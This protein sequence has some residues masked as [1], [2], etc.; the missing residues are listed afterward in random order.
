VRL[1]TIT[2]KHKRRFLSHE[3]TIFALQLLEWTGDLLHYKGFATVY[4]RIHHNLAVYGHYP[5]PH[6]AYELEER[7][8]AFERNWEGVLQKI[9]EMRKK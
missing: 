2:P 5:R 7:K 3:E 9:E 1:P 4:N 6:E 8:A